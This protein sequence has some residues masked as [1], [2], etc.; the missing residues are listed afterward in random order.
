MYPL[1]L[2]TLIH[3]QCFEYILEAPPEP[4][5]VAN[6]W[7]QIGYV[8]EILGDYV[9]AREAFEHV[10]REEPDSSKVL[11]QLGFIHSIPQTR[12]RDLDRAQSYIDRA[13]NIGIS[14]PKII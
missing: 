11:L 2:P 7:T 1:S 3:A 4:L 13:L 6:I 5:T 14:C 9:K 8:Y 12:I 10:L